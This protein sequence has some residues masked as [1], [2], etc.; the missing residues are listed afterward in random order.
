MSSLRYNSIDIII[1]CYKREKKIINLIRSLNKI[2]YSRNLIKIYIILDGFLL[3]FKSLEKLS[4][5]K[6]RI[7]YNSKNK[8]PSFSRNFAIKKSNSEYIWFLDSDAKIFN[9]KILLNFI[10]YIKQNNIDGITGY[11]EKCF[12]GYLVQTPKYFDNLINLELFKDYGSFNYEYNNM[13]AMTSLF[14]KRKKFLKKFGLFDESLRIKE[15]E[16]LIS[17]VDKGKRNFLIHRD[18]LVEHEPD[19]SSSQ[20]QILHIRNVIKIRNYIMQKRGK[21]LILLII[22]DLK[23]FLNYVFSKIFMKNEYRSR[24][25]EIMNKEISYIDLSKALLDLI[26][27]YIFKINHSTL[28]KLS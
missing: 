12:H 9:S 26:K 18:T 1:P 24:R 20:N 5:Y 3:K 17:S 4:K 16:E 6:M 15:D 8:G 13:I 2:N 22:Y 10:K 19:L 14:V 23:F 7:L 21:L 11:R 27:S 28:N 25:L